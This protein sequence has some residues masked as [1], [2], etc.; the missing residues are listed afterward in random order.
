MTTLSESEKIWQKYKDRFRKTD[1]SKFLPKKFY[2]PINIDKE[3]EIAFEQAKQK[4]YENQFPYYEELPRLSRKEIFPH[5]GIAK[6]EHFGYFGIFMGV[7]FGKV[8]G[9]MYYGSLITS[10]KIMRTRCL[11]SM[12]FST[13]FMFISSFALD[14]QPQ[15][16]GINEIQHFDEVSN[17]YF[18]LQFD[19][20]KDVND[21]KYNDQRIEKSDFK[22][23]MQILEQ[24]KLE[25]KKKQLYDEL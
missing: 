23:I 13:S 21:I 19:A 6:T 24:K 10:Y 17:R 8:V 2:E 4:Q 25:F 16:L 1:Y 3:K 7:V 14:F 5:K 18:D 22:A 12:L 20:F 9:E 11:L 15:N